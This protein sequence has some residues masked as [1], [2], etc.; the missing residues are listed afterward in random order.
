MFTHAQ[1]TVVVSLLIIIV[2]T[3]C[4][5]TLKCDLIFIMPMFLIDVICEVFICHIGTGKHTL[6]ISIVL[7]K[8]IYG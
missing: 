7:S 4:W 3:L 8:P 5:S 6:F 2:K 1:Y